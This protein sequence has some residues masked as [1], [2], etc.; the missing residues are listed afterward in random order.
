MADA[1]RRPVPQSPL[2]KRVTL[3]MGVILLI[4]IVGIGVRRVAHMESR[5]QNVRTIYDF[6]WL[7]AVLAV[8][9]VGFLPVWRARY[10][11]R[12]GR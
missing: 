6:V 8:V 4:E 10:R 3:T 1:R 7:A 12:D 2:R 9:I 11:K 5:P